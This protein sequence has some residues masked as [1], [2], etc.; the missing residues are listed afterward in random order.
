MTWIYVFTRYGTVLFVLLD[1]I[2]LYNLVVCTFYTSCL[3]QDALTDLLHNRIV[4][5]LRS[6]YTILTAYTL[7]L[8]SYLVCNLCPSSDTI[9]MLRVRV[10]VP[11]VMTSLLTFDPQAS[12]RYASMLSQLAYAGAP[13]PEWSS[14]WISSQLSQIWSVVRDHS[15]LLSS[16]S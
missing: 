2:P 3:P 15:Y 6:Q 7:Q 13:S 9:S 12:L 16:V 11:S 8:Q 4:F 5:V 10:V 14:F 1:L